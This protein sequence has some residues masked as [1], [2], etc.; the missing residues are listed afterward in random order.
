ML[1]HILA[2]TFVE[3][4]FTL[5]LFLDKQFRAVLH[6]LRK[7]EAA[8]AVQLPRLQAR[9]RGVHQGN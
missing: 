3:L 4:I 6:Q 7:R 5:T 1:N 2:T 8:A 9:P